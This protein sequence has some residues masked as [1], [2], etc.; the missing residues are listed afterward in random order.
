MKLPSTIVNE[1]LGKTFIKRKFLKI[2]KSL[3][4]GLLSYF[5]VEYSTY[6]ICLLTLKGIS[7]GVFLLE[8]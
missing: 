1:L 2:V 4:A 6:W 8:C 3:S 5:V 7:F